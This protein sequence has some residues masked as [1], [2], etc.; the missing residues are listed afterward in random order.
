MCMQIENRLVLPMQP[1]RTSLIRLS[2]V[3][4]SLV[5]LISLIEGMDLV[6]AWDFHNPKNQNH[7]R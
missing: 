6:L 4:V 3:W 2:H 1:K 5:N 7:F